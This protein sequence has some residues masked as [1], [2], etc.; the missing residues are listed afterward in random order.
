[1]AP[2]C[3]QWK[4]ANIQKRTIQAHLKNC[5]SFFGRL[6]S[7]DKVWGIFFQIN[8]ATKILVLKEKALADESILN[9]FPLVHDYFLVI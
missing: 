7:P 6:F 5:N 4:M 1:M 9:T 2:L 3:I 8:I